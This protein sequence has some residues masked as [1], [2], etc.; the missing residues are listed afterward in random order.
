MV[1]KKKN[2]TPTLTSPE[3][4]AM[5]CKFEATSPLCRKCRLDFPTLFRR[6][7]VNKKTFKEI[8]EEAG[9]STQ[10]VQKIHEKWFAPILGESGRRR[11]A[12]RARVRVASE[13]SVET[14]END[15]LCRIA[16]LSQ[17]RGLSVAHVEVPSG[18][19]V[20]NGTRRRCSSRRI[21]IN[22]KLCEV[23][24]AKSA[25]AR[26]PGCRREYFQT[27]LSRK[28]LE[29][30]HTLIFLVEIPGYPTRVFVIPSHVL[31]NTLFS[32]SR[33]RSAWFY[34]PAEPPSSKRQAPRVSVW[35]YENAWK[36]LRG[37]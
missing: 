5:R 8:G 21:I 19:I 10:A 33:R 12:R 28:F 36:F 17:K 37:E 2:P 25:A 9:V 24:H 26:N 20:R 11:E 22:G 4:K 13:M 23:R 6:F 14:S 15:L 27:T 29:E 7:K 3:V 1:T 30:T 18:P 35:E 16:K 31:L 32:G 34:I